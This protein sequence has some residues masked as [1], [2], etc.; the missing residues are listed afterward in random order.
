MFR[1]DLS[2]SNTNIDQWVVLGEPEKRSFLPIVTQNLIPHFETKK[3]PPSARQNYS[4]KLAPNLSHH[5][6]LDKNAPKLSDLLNIEFEK[7]KQSA[8]G[9]LPKIDD[10]R[11]ID[12]NQSFP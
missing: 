8:I 9:K 2:K 6:Y 7:P 1:F 12:Q 10:H 5:S 3:N 4:K 11:Q